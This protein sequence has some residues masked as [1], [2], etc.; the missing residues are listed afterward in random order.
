MLDHPDQLQYV[1]DVQ[2]QSGNTPLVFLKIDGGN[3]RAGMRVSSL[4][5]NS[6][7]KE[8]ASSD[9]EGTVVFHG[10]YIHAGNSYDSRKYGEA[11][12]HLIHEFTELAQAA[13]AIGVSNFRLPFTLSVGATPTATSLQYAATTTRKESLGDVEALTQQ[14]TQQV[15][16][17]KDRG[18]QLEIHAG[19]D[20]TL[21]LQQ[22]ATHARDCE[23][24]NSSNI[25]LTILADVASIYPGRGENGTTEAL[26][27]V[28]C[29]GLG[30]EPCKDMGVEKGVHYSGWGIPMPW[31]DA[32]F[33]NQIPTAKFPSVHGGWQV[34][35]I[36]QEHGILVWKGDKADE[37]PLEVGQR[38]RI[39]PNHACIAAAGFEHYLIV[40][41][42]HLGAEDIV[43][44][45]WP[46]W[47]GW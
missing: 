2:S 37:K 32:S 35:R 8:L 27:N 22:L 17:L 9:S 16:N 3:H 12:K 30:R 46:R 15:R 24:L 43:V 1:R 41:S 39:W 20:P 29:L 31:P 6:F 11:L 47:N 42:R 19:V 26:I 5:S 23:L 21:D 13:E 25:A 7:V 18:F 28:G 38:L 40:D 10:L 14:V 33:D 34:G 45:V 36:S 44:D 4:H